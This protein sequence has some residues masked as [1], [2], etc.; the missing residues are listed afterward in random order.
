MK[1]IKTLP[2]GVTFVRRY[3][4]WVSVGEQE[5]KTVNRGWTKEINSDKGWDVG[6]MLIIKDFESLQPYKDS[7]VHQAFITKYEPILDD[8]MRLDWE[9]I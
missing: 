9:N 7:K 5:N 6:I 4:L 1:K 3:V 2:G 8:L